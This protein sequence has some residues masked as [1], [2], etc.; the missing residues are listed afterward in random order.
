MTLARGLLIVAIAVQ[1]TAGC[2]GLTGPS[3]V[4]P[5]DELA[6]FQDRETGFSTNDVRDAQDQVL[7]F[8]AAGELIW[9]GSAARFPGFIADGAVITAEKVCSGC[10]FLV[11]FGTVRGEE[12]AYLT[13]SGEETPD[14]P[15][16]LLD[17]EVTGGGLTVANTDLTVPHD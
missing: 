13:W 17:V 5:A 6:L 9:V 1:G 3:R 4:A 8:N 2:G 12:R 16:T 7:R 15:A 10:Y 11:R 14:R